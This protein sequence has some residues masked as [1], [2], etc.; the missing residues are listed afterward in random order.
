MGAERHCPFIFHRRGASQGA[1]NQVGVDRRGSAILR[2]EVLKG[3]SANS[4]VSSTVWLHRG[5]VASML[6]VPGLLFPLI[7]TQALP[8]FQSGHEFCGTHPSHWWCHAR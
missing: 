4:G 6:A 7:W 8:A 5:M 2:T 3:C 1:S